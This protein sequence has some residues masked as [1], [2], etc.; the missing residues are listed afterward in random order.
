MCFDR[1]KIR[2]CFKK[3]TTFADKI[4]FFNVKKSDF[5]EPKLR[6]KMFRPYVILI[7]VFTA[8]SLSAQSNADCVSAMEICEKKAYTIKTTGGEG[9]DR[10]EANFMTC[11]LNGDNKGQAEENSTWIRFEIAKDGLL[12]FRITPEVKTDDI[13]FVVYRLGKDKTCASKKV[14]RCCAAGDAEVVAAESPCMGETGL[15]TGETDS[16]EDA[17]CSDEDDN[18]WLAPLKVAK[19]EHYVILVSNVTSRGPGFTIR[20]SGSAMLP[21]DEKKPPP[22]PPGKKKKKPDTPTP[23]EE[24][25]IVKNTRPEEINGRKVEI[26]DEVKVKSRTI[27]VKIWDSQIEDGDI[28]S[29]YL[30]DKRI[31]DHLYLRVKPYEFEVELPEGK[32]HYLTVYADGFGKAEPNT[33]KVSVFD[34]V[35]E[36][37]IDLVAGR[38]TQG[39]VRIITE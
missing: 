31:K 4:C 25:K 2:P 3:S 24:P 1:S 33:A 22:P 26:S 23:P 38:K 12:A 7:A 19:G 6:H 32:E 27:K 17:G 20:F 30:D 14:V 10:S 34:G 15:R 8:Q 28:V 39:S 37:I 13:D 9:A 5:Y 11:F 36:Q 21:C 16:S 35:H 18:A 29:I